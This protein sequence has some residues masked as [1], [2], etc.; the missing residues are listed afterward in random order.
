MTS[1]ISKYF[2]YNSKSVVKL[3]KLQTKEVSLLYERIKNKEYEFEYKNCICDSNNSQLIASR[4][5]FGLK[6]NTIICSDCGLIRINPRFNE[7]SYSKFYKDQYRRLYTGKEDEEH[8]NSIFQSQYKT[9]EE[10]YKFI[11][12]SKVNQNSVLDVGCSCGG[13]LKYFEDMGSSVEGVDYDPK[14]I[15]FGKRKLF[16]C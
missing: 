4:D 11:K 7:E 13:V 10:Y 12:K 5:K 6:V 16:Q 15:E 3:N 9:G 2:N 8:I 1:I 14:Y